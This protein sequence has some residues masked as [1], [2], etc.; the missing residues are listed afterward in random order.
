MTEEQ[1]KELITIMQDDVDERSE[2]GELDR[3]DLSLCS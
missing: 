3:H 1:L 2:A